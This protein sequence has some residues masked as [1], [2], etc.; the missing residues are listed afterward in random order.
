MRCGDRGSENVRN[1]SRKK[2]FLPKILQAGRDRAPGMQ[3]GPAGQLVIDRQ[4]RSPAVPVRRVRRLRVDDE[5]LTRVSIAVGSWLA[6]AIEEYRYRSALRGLMNAAVDL[7]AKPVRNCQVRR[8]FPCVL[9]VEVVG[10]AAH[11]SLVELCPDRGEC[12]GRADVVRIWRC[13]QESR[14]RVGQGAADRNIMRA[15]G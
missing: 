1:P 6:I 2:V 7:V 3:H 8:C 14:Q 4:A 13:G 11:T 10:F 12:C 5:Y 9:E 15:G